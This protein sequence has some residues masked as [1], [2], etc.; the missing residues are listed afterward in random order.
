MNIRVVEPPNVYRT[1]HKAIYRTMACIILNP[2]QRIDDSGS[3]SLTQVFDDDGD[4]GDV[5]CL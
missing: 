2:S 1:Y 4:D 5:R 3:I